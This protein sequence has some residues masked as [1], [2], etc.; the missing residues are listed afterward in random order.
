[1]LEYATGA[2]TPNPSN[3][4][5]LDYRKEAARL[6]PPPVPIIDVHAH[7]S[8][9]RAARIYKQAADLFGV[10]Q[11]HS[12]TQL[13]DTGPVRAV[14]GDRI[15]FTAVPDWRNPDRRFAHG[16]D[17]LDR[18]ERFH[19]M[20]SRIIKLFAAP[21]MRDMEA[22]LGEPGLFQLDAPSRH[23]VARIAERLGMAIMT[24]VAD[25]DTWFKARYFDASKYGTKQD[26]YTPLRR[27]LDRYQVPW[28]AAHMGGN[29]EDL[30]FLD[31]LL[32]RHPNLHLDTSACKWMIREL[33]AH[34]PGEVRGFM[35]KW[36]GRV[37]FG[38]D[39]LTTD[40]HLEPTAG[41]TE[42]EAKAG[43][44]DQAFDLYASRYWCLRVLFERT[45]S[46]ESPIVDPDLHMVDPE[47]HAADDA[48]MV[49]CHGLG[50]DLLKVIYRDA[51]S[52][53]AGRLDLP[54]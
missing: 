15:H 1:M 39:I 23:E 47:H 44:E 28:I 37:L 38:S 21:R 25:P 22:E 8:G 31:E 46:F 50:H 53:F 19:A 24:H 3:R 51:W 27:M 48:P 36:S 10:S 13:E 20:G 43:G 12:M 42:M 2:C 40:A 41:K 5:G 11:V 26:Q 16:T 34:E 45:G 17:F 33:G 29:P 7:I 35:E 52:G 54:A 18:I 9:E 14:L 49:T 4:H 6:G 32:E 30:G